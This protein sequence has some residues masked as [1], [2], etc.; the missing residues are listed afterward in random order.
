[1]YTVLLVQC[2]I[3]SICL[4]SRSIKLVMIFI[5][6]CILSYCEYVITMIY[7]MS[8]V[9]EQANSYFSFIP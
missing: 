6:C 2:D 8:M 4:L 7:Q 9:C 3:L 1:M 5:E